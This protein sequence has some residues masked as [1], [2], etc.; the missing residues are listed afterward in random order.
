MVLVSNNY[1]IDESRPC[2]TYGTRG[3]INFNVCIEG[4]RCDLDSRCSPLPTY[5]IAW[6]VAM[7]LIASRNLHSGVDGGAVVE[8]MTDL[9]GVLSSLADSHG[10]VLVPK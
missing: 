3:V 10:Q 8:P 4:A 7:W 6:D 1:W 5:T 2:L 9:L